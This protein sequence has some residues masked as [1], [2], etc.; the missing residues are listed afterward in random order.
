MS[1]ISAPSE[2]DQFLTD[3]WAYIAAEAVQNF[4]PYA[5]AAPGIVL[6]IFAFAILHGGSLTGG[7]TPHL[8]SM[9]LFDILVLLTELILRLNYHVLGVRN[10]WFCKSI[11]FVQAAATN[12]SNVLTLIVGIIRS[13]VVVFPIKFRHLMKTSRWIVQISGTVVL[14]FGLQVNKFF[15]KTIKLDTCIWMGVIDI[16]QKVIGLLLTALYC[17]SLICLT[18]CSIIMFSK[19]REQEKILSSLSET[20]M[21]KSRK[22]IQLGRML[23][24]VCVL[25]LS[26]RTLP[27]VLLAYSLLS[28]MKYKSTGTKAIFELLT[29][30]SRL[31]LLMGHALNMCVYVLDSSIFRARAKKIFGCGHSTQG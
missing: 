20:D 19:L 8:T 28:D 13:L 11:N 23:L 22:D 5:I 6:N 4:G 9:A 2:L 29:K 7:V 14:F 17:F 12:S 30:I 27:I 25:Y 15:V 21:T 1:D 26:T 16:P 3:H 31:I 10:Q 18:V 24:G